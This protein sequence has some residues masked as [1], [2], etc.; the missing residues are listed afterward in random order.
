MVSQVL[1]TKMKTAENLT[2]K[3]FATKISSI[4]T[5]MKKIQLLHSE[6][7]Y[8]YLEKTSVVAL[9]NYSCEGK[10]W[11]SFHSKAFRRGQF[12]YEELHA[13]VLLVENLIDFEVKSKIIAL[14]VI[15]PLKSP[16]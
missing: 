15:R 5:L 7:K 12:V 4:Q 1:G 14:L 8:E 11:R 6:K 13:P 16:F 2:E 3:H 9:S 10:N